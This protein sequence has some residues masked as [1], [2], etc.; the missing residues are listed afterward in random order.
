VLLFKG[1]FLV[2]LLSAPSNKHDKEKRLYLIISLG[3]N[4]FMSIWAIQGGD[5]YG[6]DDGAG[7]FTCTIFK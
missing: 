4:R 7:C 2:A 6:Q 3:D 5:G 1:C